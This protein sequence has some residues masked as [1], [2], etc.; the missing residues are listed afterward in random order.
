MMMTMKKKKTNIVLAGSSFKDS[1]GD[2]HQAS[3]RSQVHN[4]SRLSSLLGYFY[5]SGAMSPA[6]AGS[7]ST[8]SSGQVLGDWSMSPSL[9]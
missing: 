2:I 1:R 6:A 9:V 3:S 5:S 8:P 7:A 4:P